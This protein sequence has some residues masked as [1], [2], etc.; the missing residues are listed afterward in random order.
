MPLSVDED[1]LRVIAG[2][3]VASA[4][5]QKQDGRGHRGGS[6]GAGPGRI[7][8][9]SVLVGAQVERGCI[10]ATAS[11]R[12]TYAMG[13]PQMLRPAVEAEWAKIAPL[14]DE[15]T[16]LG[17]RVLLIVAQPRAERDQRQGRRREAERRLRAAGADSA[18]GRASTARW[19]GTG[20]VRQRRRAHQDH[21]RRRPGHR[22]CPRSSGGADRRPAVD[23]G[24]RAGLARRL[25]RSAR[26]PQRTMV[27][28]R[29]TPAQKERLVDSLRMPA[30]TW[31]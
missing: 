20:A 19:R 12:G 23:L 10:S 14:V 3:V 9:R 27:F 16:A 24:A 18:R 26:W 6:A 7:D 8:G 11:L 30:T 5:E 15:R 2:T 4:D 22:R 21:F 28:G 31:R 13:A 29:I 1:H 25:H 17:L